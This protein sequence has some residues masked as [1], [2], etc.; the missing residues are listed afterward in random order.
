M[1]GVNIIKTSRILLI[2]TYQMNSLGAAGVVLL[3]YRVIHLFLDEFVIINILYLN[4]CR[5][6]EQVCRLIA[7]LIVSQLHSSL[8][9]SGIHC[10]APQ[11]ETHL[12]TGDKLESL[13]QID[14]RRERLQNVGIYLILTQ[15]TI[16]HCC[17]TFSISITLNM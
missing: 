4:P 17:V 8:Q 3:W 10:L 1:G 14:R 16:T 15:L 6:S 12:A 7:H 9:L 5:L 13:S 11:I 2:D